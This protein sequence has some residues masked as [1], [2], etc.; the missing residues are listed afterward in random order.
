MPQFDTYV[1]KVLVGLVILVTAILF[2]Y[3]KL[4]IV[5][6]STQVTKL[7]EKL[8]NYVVRFNNVK[9]SSSLRKFYEA[10]I[11]FFKKN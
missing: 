5:R 9:K 4:N 2:M 7:R 3:V 8:K 6:T 10:S 1:Y 11:K